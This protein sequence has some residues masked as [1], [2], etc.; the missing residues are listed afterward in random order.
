MYRQVCY[1][2][3][4]KRD[5]P[6]VYPDDVA[7]GDGPQHRLRIAAGTAPRALWLKLSPFFAKAGFGGGDRFDSAEV[8]DDAAT[9]GARLTLCIFKSGD[10]GL[11]TRWVF[12]FPPTFTFTPTSEYVNLT[13]RGLPCV[14][15]HV[16]VFRFKSRPDRLTPGTWFRRNSEY[17]KLTVG[18]DVQDLTLVVGQGEF[19]KKVV[20]CI[21]VLCESEVGV[22]AVFLCPMRSSS[23]E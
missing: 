2:V 1:G 5:L 8:S 3:L 10:S 11:G 23:G 19:T 4:P 20:Y 13:F 18:A 6:S 7:F 21:D 9:D 22:R 16:R 12:L 15:S 14:G 17:L